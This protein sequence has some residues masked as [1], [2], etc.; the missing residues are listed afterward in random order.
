MTSPAGNVCVFSAPRQHYE[1][2]KR[3][4]MNE[5][6][7]IQVERRTMKIVL[8]CVLFSWIPDALV[9]AGNFRHSLRL[10]LA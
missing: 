5:K 6:R 1:I 8:D 10:V 2:E 4:T 3:W 9:V 7:G